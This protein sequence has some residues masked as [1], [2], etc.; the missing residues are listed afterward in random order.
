MTFGN[1]DKMVVK[2]TEEVLDE[3]DSDAGKAKNKDK[4]D[5]K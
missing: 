3:T 2:V 4:A 1:N 5:A